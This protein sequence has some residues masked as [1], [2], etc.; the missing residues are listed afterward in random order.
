MIGRIDHPTII[1]EESLGDKIEGGVSNLWRDSIFSKAFGAGGETFM[2]GI[3]LIKPI[4]TDYLKDYWQY[5]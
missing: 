2:K 3:D 5:Y 4:A 1:K